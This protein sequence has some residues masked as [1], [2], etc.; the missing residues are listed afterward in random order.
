MLE[1]ERGKKERSVTF[2]HID[3]SK[4]YYSAKLAKYFFNPAVSQK[5]LIRLELREKVLLKKGVLFVAKAVLC[6]FF[7]F[8]SINS[9]VHPI[10]IKFFVWTPIEGRIFCEYNDVEESSFL[11]RLK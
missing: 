6:N 4:K 2:F 11:Y 7:H 8:I 9:T 10:L 3:F 1:R 5:I